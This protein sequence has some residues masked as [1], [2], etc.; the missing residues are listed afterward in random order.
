V[1]KIID[2]MFVIIRHGNIFRFLMIVLLIASSA[3]V[4]RA[5]D[6]TEQ[7]IPCSSLS[8]AEF[9]PKSDAEMIL[10]TPVFIHDSTCRRS[11]NAYMGYL[12]KFRSLKTD[13]TRI[14]RAELICG[15]DQYASPADAHRIYEKVK[16]ENEKMDDFKVSALSGIGEEGF[17]STDQFG[18][19]TLYI[20]KKSR[21]YKYSCL[22]SYSNN[23]V[24]KLSEIVA[25][26]ISSH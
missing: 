8:T 9:M 1:K 5:D 14:G 11:G 4:M 7:M 25:K 19:P 26:A 21:N 22:Y 23:A 17:I 16:T 20:R 15:F 13:T 6:P 12:F 18:N 3:L 24:E 2:Q 10:G